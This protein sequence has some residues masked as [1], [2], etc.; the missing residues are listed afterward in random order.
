MGGENIELAGHYFE[1]PSIGGG[2]ERQTFRLHNVTGQEIRDIWIKTGP[3][4]LLEIEIPIFGESGNPPDV[5]GLKINDLGPVHQPHDKAKAV[6]GWT[7]NDEKR[8]NV[9]DEGPEVHVKG[10][11]WPHCHVWEFKVEFDDEFEEA[12]YIEFSPTDSDSYVIA[13]PHPT[14]PKPP[15]PGLKAILEA[16]AKGA[17]FSGKVKKG[18]K[19]K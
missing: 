6:T 8:L 13:A 9:V 7:T 4:G 5:K 11:T 17:N 12:E 16:G 1:K 14:E 15:S 2:S 10:L 19:D 3:I 18:A